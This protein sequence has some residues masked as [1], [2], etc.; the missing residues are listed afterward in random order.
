MNKQNYLEQI[1]RL[2]QRL[3]EEDRERSLAFYAESIDDRMEDGLSEEAAVASMES[4]EKAAEAILMDMPIPKLVKA[5]VKERR[6]G[7]AEILLLALGF[8][9]WFPLLLTVLILGLTVYL[10]VWALVLALGAVVLALGLSAAAL[11]VAGVYSII[12]A[13]I[14]LG[15]LNFGAA[16]VLT[17]LTVLL[18]FVLVWA[19][20]LAV[21]L[22]KWM[23]RG[24]KALLIRKE[25]K[26]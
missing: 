15:V 2:L 7:A 26:T 17:G 5:R 19:G 20:K 12:K 22:G 3:P 14:S 18:G 11:L 6:M 8:P 16:L 4:P 1:R 10:L 13:A 23:V 9:L 25:D 24:L 21:K